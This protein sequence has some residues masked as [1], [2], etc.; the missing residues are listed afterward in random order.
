M[1]GDVIIRKKQVRSLRVVTE[2]VLSDDNSA[3]RIRHSLLLRFAQVGQL[4]VPPVVLS[5]PVITV[6]GGCRLDPN[7]G[8]RRCCDPV[9]FRGCP[10]WF[11]VAD[12]ARSFES[13]QC[14]SNTPTRDPCFLW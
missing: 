1:E 4:L 5:V 8:S 3:L 11:L 10:I 12:E 14:R 6:R 7:E 2:W 13:V 9:V